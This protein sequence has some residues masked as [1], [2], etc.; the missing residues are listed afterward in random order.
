M[1]RFASEMAN[2]LLSLF[3]Q[4][5]CTPHERVRLLDALARWDAR[6]PPAKQHVVFNRF[7]F[8]FDS[9]DGSIV[10]DDI[11]DASEAGSE[12]LSA[13]ELKECLRQ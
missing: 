12:H 9:E 4:Q 11:L 1:I 3:M 13:D 10:V 7:E 2:K 5:D 8:T 6:E